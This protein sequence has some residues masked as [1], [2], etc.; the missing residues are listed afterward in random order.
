MNIPMAPKAFDFAELMSSSP[1]MKNGCVC[2][3]T[4]TN[5]YISRESDGKRDSEEEAKKYN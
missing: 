1:V 4:P 5:S 3:K 2:S